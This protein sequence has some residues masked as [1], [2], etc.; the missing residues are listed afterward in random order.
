MDK[1]EDNVSLSFVAYSKNN[2]YF[3]FY[4][5]F[6]TIFAVFYEICKTLLSYVQYT[7]NSE[8]KL[9]LG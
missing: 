4:F 7:G 2:F 3:F 5:H 6:F 8:Q 9:F 1:V